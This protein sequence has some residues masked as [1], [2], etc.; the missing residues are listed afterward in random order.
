MDRFLPFAAPVLCGLWVLLCLR[1]YTLISRQNEWQRRLIA[2]AGG[3]GA[4]LIYVLMNLLIPILRAPSPSEAAPAN[5]EEV[6]V[7]LKS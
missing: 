7:R 3:L 2:V 1:F 6:R 5:G 4:G